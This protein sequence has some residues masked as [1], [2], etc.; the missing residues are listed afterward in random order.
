GRWSTDL[1]QVLGDRSF[2]IY[3]DAQ[4]TDRRVDAVSRAIDAGKHVYCE[5][6]TALSTA[7]AVD[8]FR[9]A[10]KKGVRHGVVQDKLWLPGIRKLAGL[11]DSGF[12]GRTL[13]VRGE[14]GYWVFTG[15]DVPAQRPSWNYRAESGGGVVLDMFC[16]W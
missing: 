4:T 15:H 6:P 2:G 10:E 3:F 13:S 7:A 8:L 5:K 14:F 11:R 12:F 1:D 9:R 16:H